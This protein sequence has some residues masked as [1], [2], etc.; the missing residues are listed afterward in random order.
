MVEELSIRLLAGSEAN[1]RVLPIPP[2]L[3]QPLDFDI[4]A[5]GS[6]EDVAVAEDA[7]IVL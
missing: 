1:L 4:G 3:H 2:F 5:A 7:M 6:L